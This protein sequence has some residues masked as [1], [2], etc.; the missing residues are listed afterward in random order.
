VRIFVLNLDDYLP[1]LV[2][3]LG[4]RIAAAFVAHLRKHRLTL[5]MWR[6]LAALAHHGPQNLG[7]LARHTTIDVSTLSR[8]IGSL[9]RRKLATRT[10][11]SGDARA[12]V[13]AI[14]EPGVALV[15]SLAPTARSYEKIAL[16]GF[17]ADDSRQ[18]KALLRRAHT[19][20]DTGLTGKP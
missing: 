9:V 15:A 7:A 17:S 2:N 4:A 19:N 13:V 3:R 16:A 12:V 6:A 18:L 1:Y 20:L 5:A 8:V 11:Q 14:S 10:R